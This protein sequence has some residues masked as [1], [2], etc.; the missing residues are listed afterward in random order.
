ML[1]EILQQ[2]SPVVLLVKLTNNKLKKRYGISEE[3]DYRKNSIYKTYLACD[4]VSDEI[5]L[6]KHYRCNKK[7]IGFNNRKYLSFKA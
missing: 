4:A 6:K 2:L 5:L 1:I 3:Y 7:I